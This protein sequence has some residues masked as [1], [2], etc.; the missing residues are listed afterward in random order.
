MG[1]LGSV[2]IMLFILSVLVVVHE[3]GHYFAARIFKVK[4]EEFAIF[5]G[6][7]L[8]SKVSKKTGTRWSIRAFPIGGY[9]ALEGEEETVKSSTSFVSK[10][11]YMRAA[12]LLAGPLMNILLA[13]IIIISMFLYTGMTLL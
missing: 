9:C 5:M 1:I 4:V 8:F 10:P 2:L 11:W 12:I 6:P 3:L 13:I 7:K